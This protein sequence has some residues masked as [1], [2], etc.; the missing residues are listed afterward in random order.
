ML[1]VARKASVPVAV[2]LHHG[3]TLHKLLRAL[4]THFTSVMVHAS[5]TNFAHNL[6]Q[7]KTIVKI[8]KP[9]LLSVTAELGPILRTGSGDKL[10][11]YA[12]L[13]KTYT[14]PQTAKQLLTQSGLH[15][16]AVH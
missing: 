13:N 1:N 2:T 5:Q 14:L 7:T 15:M 11:H 3:T 9:L 6:A 4:R 12:D 16:L 10:V 8:C